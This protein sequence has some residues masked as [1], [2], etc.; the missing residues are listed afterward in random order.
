M[1]KGE[2]ERVDFWDGKMNEQRWT[3]KWM[4]NEPTV[5]KAGMEAIGV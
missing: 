2:E 4:S 5:E 1:K 3:G